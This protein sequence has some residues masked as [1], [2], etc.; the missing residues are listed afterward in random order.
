MRH[1]EE[2][3][4]PPHVVLL[5][6]L[7]AVDGEAAAPAEGEAA[8]AVDRL[9][10]LVGQGKEAWQEDSRPDSS[11]GGELELE[12][13]K[14]DRQATQEAIGWQGGVSDQIP[15]SLTAYI[16]PQVHTFDRYLYNPNTK[17]YTVDRYLDD[18]KT[19]YGGID[20]VLLWPVY[21]QLGVDDRNQFDMWRCMPGGLDGVANL[22]AQFHNHGVK[23]LWPELP[24]DRGTRREP[25]SDAKI[26]RASCRERV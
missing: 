6:H 3:V 7:S 9:K 10:Q 15:W 20:A 18:L 4:S 13:L 16:Q 1:G 8:A 22:T 11:C 26:G 24:W 23:V 21:P 25:L 17:S 14:A 2:S 19:R 12:E 5:E